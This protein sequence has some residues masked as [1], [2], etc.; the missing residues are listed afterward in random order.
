MLDF[1]VRVAVE[2]WYI[3]KEASIFLL[4][5]F[6]LA[7]VLAVLVRGSTL[8]NLF[9]RGKV[10]SVMWASAI[11][12]PLPLCSCGVIPAA[13]GL[14]REGA[15]K[16]ATV[17]FLIS[18]PETG[19]DSIAVTYALMDPLIGTIRPVTAVATAITAGLTTNF[20]DPG[21][22][23]TPPHIEP[24]DSA[25]HH[26]GMAHAGHQHSHLPGDTAHVGCDHV[27]E[28]GAFVHVGRPRPYDAARQI[29]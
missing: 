17:S 26:A 28:D 10:R 7:G 8:R 18:T 27:H 25:P 13:L 20:L 1:L 5:G 19:V 14:R 3:L 9:G 11:G 15:T 22:N 29:Y 4:F 2:T 23:Q 24:P 16:G 6:A 12:I 21:A